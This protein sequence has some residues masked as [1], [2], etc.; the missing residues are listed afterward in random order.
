MFPA[1]AS[2][3]FLANWLTPDEDSLMA[4]NYKIDSVDNTNPYRRALYLGEGYETQPWSIFNGT[5]FDLTRLNLDSVYWIEYL[6]QIEEIKT[7]G[8][9]II[10]T[11]ILDE[12]TIRKHLGD[13]TYITIWPYTNIFGYI[14]STINKNTLFNLTQ[15]ERENINIEILLRMID[16]R[17]NEYENFSKF[18]FTNSKMLDYG[19]IYEIDYLKDIYIEIIGKSPSPAR[20]KWAERY[21]AKQGKPIIDTEISDYEGLKKQ[22]DPQSL[23]DLSILLYLYEKNN[24][25]MRRCWT[26]DDV[27]LDFKSAADFLYKNR[28]N[29]YCP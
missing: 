25:K 1:G 8:R 15:S 27:P 16:N 21:I 3:N 23:I 18:R 11:H 9:P 4:P 17:I 5:V 12:V 2:G 26:I 29:Y 22:I 28:H 20:T 6:R 10:I 14:R 19:K 24:P 7:S 13:A